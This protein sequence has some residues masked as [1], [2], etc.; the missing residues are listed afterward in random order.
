MLRPTP[1]FKGGRGNPA[2]FPQKKRCNLKKRTPPI[3][4]PERC[5]LPV[6]AT[7]EKEAAPLAWR[8]AGCRSGPCSVF[9]GGVLIFGQNV[10]AFF[11]L[12]IEKRSPREFVRAIAGKLCP[13]ERWRI[14]AMKQPFCTPAQ[15]LRRVLD[16]AAALPVPATERVPLDGC[17]WADRSPG[18][19]CPDGSAPF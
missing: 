19:V 10:S 11:H 16:A 1:A 17:L 8:P 14:F 12:P 2:A 9:C 13:G 4:V 15:A 18:P 7:A 3:T 6:A 5:L